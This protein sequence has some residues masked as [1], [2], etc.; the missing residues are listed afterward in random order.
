MRNRKTKFRRILILCRNTVEKARVKKSIEKIRSIV[1]KK[2]IICIIEKRYLQF[3]PGYYAINDLIGVFVKVVL[4]YKE[5]LWIFVTGKVNRCY[6]NF[7]Y[8][9]V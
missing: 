6:C 7:P 2:K 9:I 1:K 3:N 4:V 8:R 5:L